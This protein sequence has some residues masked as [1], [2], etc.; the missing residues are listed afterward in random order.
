[1]AFFF[2]ECCQHTKKIMNINAKIIIVFWEFIANRKID[3]HSVSVS[4]YTDKTIAFT[5]FV[6]MAHLTESDVTPLHVIINIWKYP[7][8]GFSVS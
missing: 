4:F 5:I 7:V 8:Y 6:N 1:M 2:H 3:G